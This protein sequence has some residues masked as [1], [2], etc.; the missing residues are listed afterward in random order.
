MDLNKL[1][2]S[3]AG[4]GLR[5]KETGKFLR[6]KISIATVYGG[7]LQEK[8][9]DVWLV[10]TPEHAEYVRCNSTFI[11]KAGGTHGLP[12]H[13]INS[14]EYEV[15]S[16]VDKI[17]SSKVIFSAIPSFIRI[18]SWL[19]GKHFYAKVGKEDVF[20]DGEQKWDSWDKAYTAALEYISRYL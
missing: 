18:L 10:E 7:T 14:D 9:G 6:Y 16:L 3:S 4:Y 15:A 1:G 13:T 2:A 20:I 8:E 12:Q 17:Y 5:H 19:D 11:H